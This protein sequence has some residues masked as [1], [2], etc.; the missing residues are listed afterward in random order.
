M[1]FQVWYSDDDGDADCPACMNGTCI[2]RVEAN[3]RTMEIHK[4]IHDCADEL[5]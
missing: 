3:P 4:I 5:N 1:P 2:Q